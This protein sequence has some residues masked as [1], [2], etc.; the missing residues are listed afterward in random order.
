MAEEKIY[1]IEI[2]LSE[3]ELKQFMSEHNALMLG[4]MR[5]HITAERFNTI[6]NVHNQIT[7][8]QGIIKRGDI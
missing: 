6:W 2:D 8:A 4:L 5:K 1:H 7:M 3:T